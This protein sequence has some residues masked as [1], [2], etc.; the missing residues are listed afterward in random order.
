MFTKRLVALETSFASQGH[1]DVGVFASDLE[2]DALDEVIARWRNGED[3]PG[4]QFVPC[5]SKTG[6][7]IPIRDR[8]TA[9]LFVLVDL[10]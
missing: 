3:S 6:F 9:K 2:G 8:K 4:R 10:Q 7:L 5:L 1:Q